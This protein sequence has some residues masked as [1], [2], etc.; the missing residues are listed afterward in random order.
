MSG[1]A[2]LLAEFGATVSGSDQKDSDVFEDLRARHV[3][4]YVGHDA[5][6][7]AGAEVVLWSPAVAP[8]NVELVAA[9][10]AGAD[11]VPRARAFEEL[12]AMKRVVGFAGTHGK[13]T[14]GWSER[15]FLAWEPRVTGVRAICSSKWTRVMAHSAN[16]TPSRSA[17]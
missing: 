16:S 5:A 14:G 4:T 12:S 1:L 13:T 7:V 17:S 10:E 2:M 11:M 15:R 8:D 9:R 3:T 6:H